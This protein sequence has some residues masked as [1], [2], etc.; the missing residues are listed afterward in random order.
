MEREKKG[1]TNGVVGKG[2]LLNN[3]SLVQS[4]KLKNPPNLFCFFKTR[5]GER[6]NE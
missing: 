1:G 2:A 3:G 5:L 4:K 6:F